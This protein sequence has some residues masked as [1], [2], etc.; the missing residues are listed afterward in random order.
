MYQK[1][2]FFKTGESWANSQGLE[3]S[4]VEN[5]HCTEDKHF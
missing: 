3:A 5:G 4:D 2:S 1:K